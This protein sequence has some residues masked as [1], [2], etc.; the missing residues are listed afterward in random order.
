MPAPSGPDSSGDGGRQ[1]EGT[2]CGH[3]TWFR[4]QGSG[5]R[6]QGSGFRVQGSGCRVQGA[7]C[8]VEGS[9]FRDQQRGIEGAGGI[10]LLMDQLHFW[11]LVVL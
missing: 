1:V 4:V 2:G 7:G 5:F 3:A 8:R 6:V 11:W 10:R 9:G